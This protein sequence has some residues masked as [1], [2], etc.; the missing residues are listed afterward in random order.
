[1]SSGRFDPPFSHK[2][3]RFR[4]NDQ[5]GRQTDLSELCLLIR[6]AHIS[7]IRGR[8][9]YRKKQAGVPRSGSRIT[10][11]NVRFMFISTSPQLGNTT[12]TCGR[13]SRNNE[14]VSTTPLRHRSSQRLTPCP[15]S[16][17]TSVTEY[18]TAASLIH[19][20]LEQTVMIIEHTI[21]P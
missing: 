5:T 13:R 9:A 11:T 17:S 1:M 2:F 20:D 21:F 3:L 16:G 19:N 14:T 6:T 4:K 8:F 7:N 10:K 18:G 15:L 12:E